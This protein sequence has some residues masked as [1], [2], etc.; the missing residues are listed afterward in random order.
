M[1]SLLSSVLASK[2]AAERSQ[3]WHVGHKLPAGAVGNRDYFELAD[4]LLPLLSSVLA[5]TC[6]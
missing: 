5:S 2:C 3:C 6:C 4:Q 1:L